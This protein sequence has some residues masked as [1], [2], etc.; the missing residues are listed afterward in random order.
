M[1]TATFTQARHLKAPEGTTI[2]LKQTRYKKFGLCVAEQ[3]NNGLLKVGKDEQK[4]P[5]G[6]IERHEVLWNYRAPSLRQRKRCRVARA[7]QYFV[8]APMETEGKW[9]SQPNSNLK[10]IL[11]LTI[12]IHRSPTVRSCLR[13]IDRNRTTPP[14]CLHN[15]SIF[16]S[17]DV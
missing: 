7:I 3:A 10:A 6:M 13:T 4:D 1:R 16:S 9:F 11:V 2:E 15:P 5:Q 14:I 8:T 17:A 12:Y